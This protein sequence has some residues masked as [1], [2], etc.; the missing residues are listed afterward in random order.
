[1]IHSLNPDIP[2]R[3]DLKLQVAGPAEP[4]G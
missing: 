3:Y 1:V 4:A 2:I